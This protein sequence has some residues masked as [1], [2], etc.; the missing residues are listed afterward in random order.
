MGVKKEINLEEKAGSRDGLPETLKGNY[1]ALRSG[2]D[3]ENIQD[4]VEHH[5]EGQC[6]SRLNARPH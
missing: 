1:D 6:D 2:G 5:D 3:E 4:N